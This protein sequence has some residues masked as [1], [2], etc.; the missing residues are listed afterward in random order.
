M[1]LLRYERVYS[2]PFETKIMLAWLGIGALG[3]TAAYDGSQTYGAFSIAAAL[4]IYVIWRKAIVGVDSPSREPGRLWITDRRG[5][6]MN[7]AG[8][9]ALMGLLTMP[10]DLRASGLGGAC[11]LVAAGLVLASS[12]RFHRGNGIKRPW[13]V[14]VKTFAVTMALM[15]AGVAAMLG[16]ILAEMRGMELDPMFNQALIVAFIAIPAGLS[17]W[18][19]IR[20]QARARDDLRP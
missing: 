19:S 14:T 16:L 15:L 6:L 10:S 13:Q 12:V 3:A 11:L 2:S 20:A 1:G 17:V 5:S 8:I 4:M 9:A 7:I 18:Y